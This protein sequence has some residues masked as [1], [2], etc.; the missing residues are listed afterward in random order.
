MKTNRLIGLVVAAVAAVSLQQAAAQ[1]LDL[2][3]YTTGSTGFYTNNFDSLGYSTNET[4]DGTPSGASGYLAGEW[5][6]FV[7]AT[8]NGFGTIAA[9]APNNVSGGTM[10]VW[11]NPFT[12]GF[13][14]Y[15]SY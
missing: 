7:N 4:V 15:A 6:C 14:N 3:A 12:G 10:N 2:S 9:G 11:T 1:P 13:M 5:T 8:A